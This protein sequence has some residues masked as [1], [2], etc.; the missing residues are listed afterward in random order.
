MSR[1]YTSDK[2]INELRAENPLYAD[3]EMLYFHA[4]YGADG[5]FYDAGLVAY[6]D[7]H[8]ADSYLIVEARGF[9][10]VDGFN[11]FPLEA[12]CPLSEADA[13]E[14]Y[15]HFLVENCPAV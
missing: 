13:A 15:Q 5:V 9:E 1:Y 3:A 4:Q 7:W 8:G 14:L 6:T 12:T 10:W 11:I 2:L